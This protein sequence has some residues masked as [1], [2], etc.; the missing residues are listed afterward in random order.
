LSEEFEPYQFKT[1]KNKI[2]MSL[3]NVTLPETYDWV[4]L[5]A[6]SPVRD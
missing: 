4:E 2:F 6:V 5:H 3:P 1:N